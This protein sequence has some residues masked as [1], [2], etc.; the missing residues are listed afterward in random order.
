MI[1]LSISAF[2]DVGPWS[3][4]RGYDTFVQATTGL[5]ID[6]GNAE[7]ERLPCQPLDY[8]T[9]YLC[10]FGAMVALLKR[11]Q[12]GG[13]WHV[14]LSLAR[15]ANWLWQMSDCMQPEPNPPLSNPTLSDVQPL[16]Y[17]RDTPFGLINALSPVI[18]LSATPARFERPPVPLGTHPAVWP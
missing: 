16:C 5:A 3:G 11:A 1:C 6:R 12:Q 17:E 4:R 14:E 18:Q 7:P 2:S 13:S 9:G 15:T 8:I 10:A